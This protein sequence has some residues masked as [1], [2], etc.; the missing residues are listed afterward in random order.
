M[1][2]PTVHTAVPAG[3]DPLACLAAERINAG[4]EEIRALLF[5]DGA[6]VELVEASPATGHVVLRLL[7]TDA[8]CVL[9]R[10]MPEAV[11]LDV[12]HRAAPRPTTV[13]IDTSR[14]VPR[15]GEERTP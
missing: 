5:A 15:A 10:P 14:A 13:V 9:P 11:A 3:G 12:L 8:A 6:D 1:P 7:L 2:E 4:V